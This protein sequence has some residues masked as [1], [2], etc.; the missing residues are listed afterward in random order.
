MRFWLLAA[1]EEQK[2]PISI[3]APINQ[4]YLGMEQGARWEIEIVVS[5]RCRSFGLMF[6]L[7]MGPFA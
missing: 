4:L 1:F 5:S 6:N 7:D 3:L 2:K